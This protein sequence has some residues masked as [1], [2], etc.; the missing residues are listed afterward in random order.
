MDPSGRKVASQLARKLTGHR[1]VR[2][3]DL[4]GGLL[5][6]FAFHNDEGAGAL[7]GW[8]IGPCSPDEKNGDGLGSTMTS[9]AGT[10]RKVQQ[11]SPPDPRTGELIE[12]GRTW[13]FWYQSEIPFQTLAVVRIETPEA[14]EALK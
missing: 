4:G 7:F 2:G 6:Y 5:R 10:Q 3:R 9:L 14:W 12:T 1:I 13:G 11:T 8:Q